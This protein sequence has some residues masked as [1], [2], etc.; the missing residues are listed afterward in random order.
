MSNPSRRTFVMSL[1]AGSTVIGTSRVAAQ[2]AA[3]PVTESDPQAAALGFK[4]DTTKVDKAKF[5]KHDNTQVCSGCQLYQGKATDPVAPC[6]L[7]A[8]KT[9]PAKGWC[10]AWV[11]KA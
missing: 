7:F 10:S 9:V 6:Q 11:K 1:V 4:T 2:A 3:A 5:P 8:G